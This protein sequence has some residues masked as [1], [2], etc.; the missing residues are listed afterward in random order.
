MSV[1][2]I[3]PD[4]VKPPSRA[5]SYSEWRA[6]FT[7]PERLWAFDA[8]RPAQIRDMIAVATAANSVDLASPAVAGF[9]DLCISLGSPLTAARKA[10]VL[11]GTPPQ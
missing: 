3:N 8:A 1:I 6:L 4:K 2:T 9:L 7:E 11:A 5:V 10:A